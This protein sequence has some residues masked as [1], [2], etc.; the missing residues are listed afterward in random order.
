MSSCVALGK[1]HRPRTLPEDGN[2]KPLLT[3]LCLG[4]PGKGCYKSELTCSYIIIIIGISIMGPPLKNLHYTLLYTENADFKF[5]VKMMESMKE[6][7]GA[8]RDMF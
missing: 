7:S 2:G 1:L 6:G 5:I 3:A 4:N 8:A